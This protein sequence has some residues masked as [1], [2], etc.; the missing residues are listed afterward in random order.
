MS[1][2]IEIQPVT[3]PLDAAVRPPG[4]KSLTN[5]ALVCAALAQ[6]TS[7]LTGVLDSEDTRV[8][9]AA[10]GD[11]GLLMHADHATQTVEVQGCGGQI[12][13]SAAD[14]Y[15]ANSG[16][17]I[18]FPGH[19][20]LVGLGHGTYRLHGTPRMHERPIADLL[21]ALAQLGVRAR[22][23][24]GTGCPPVI[25]EADGLRLARATVRS[26]V[27]SQFASALLLVSPCARA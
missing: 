23:E 21:D 19:A 2:S 25:I 18:R 4:S 11:L 17:T 12:P 15:I 5:R 6:G 27:S 16:T 10:L 8:M 24:A 22:S 1:A 9:I 26:D 3:A 20:R 7:Q 13:K 14:L